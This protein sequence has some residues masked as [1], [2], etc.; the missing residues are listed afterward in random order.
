MKNVQLNS[1]WF[2]FQFLNIIIIYSFL[3]YFKCKFLYG[4]IF[5]DNDMFIF[6]FQITLNAKFS[7]V[8][9]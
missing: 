3:N 2:D 4:L 5:F 1:L 8:I 9:F 7:L 6:N